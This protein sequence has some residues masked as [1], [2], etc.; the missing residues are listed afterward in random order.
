MLLALVNLN[1]ALHPDAKFLRCLFV[2][3]LFAVSVQLASDLLSRRLLGIRVFYTARA[4][5]RTQTDEL[6]RSAIFL[7]FLFVALLACMGSLADW[8][9]LRE[10]HA[11]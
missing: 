8:V 11:A 7:P 3:I 2:F 6:I 10:T 4:T 1:T 9:Q 5:S